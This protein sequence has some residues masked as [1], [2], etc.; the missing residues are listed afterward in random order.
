MH[1]LVAS[2]VAN[3][4]NATVVGF[5]ALGIAFMLR[6][7]VALTR[8]QKTSLVRCRMEYRISSPLPDALVGQVRPWT[9]PKP[10][11]KEKEYDRY[12]LSPGTPP[13]AKEVALTRE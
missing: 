12:E 1:I 7:L 11:Q 9:Q 13:A 10:S 4:G 3:L 5:C 6:F 8:E 2:L